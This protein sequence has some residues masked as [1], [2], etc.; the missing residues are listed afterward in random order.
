MIRILRVFLTLSS[1]I[2]L[3]GLMLLWELDM[4]TEISFSLSLAMFS[5]FQAVFG[6]LAWTVLSQLGE[7]S[8]ARK[9]Q[10]MMEKQDFVK[11]GNFD[12]D[13][14]AKSGKTVTELLDSLLSME[15]MLQQIL[16]NFTLVLYCN[17]HLWL[18]CHFSFSLLHFQPSGL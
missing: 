1:V 2:R 12:F 7:P 11:Y 16:I 14:N 15:G 9:M 8:S 6:G 3:Q 13:E 10:D 4:Y 18:C 5:C 17:Y